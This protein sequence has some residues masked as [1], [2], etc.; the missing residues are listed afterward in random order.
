MNYPGQGIFAGGSLRCLLGLLAFGLAFSPAADVSAQ[1]RV[2]DQPS[3]VIAIARGSSALLQP[4]QD[5]QRVLVGDP[6]IADYA[7]V[8]PQE[9]VINAIGVG[10][11]SLFVWDRAD[12]VRMYTVAVTP[13]VGAL[14]RQLDMLFP[15]T[16]IELTASGEAV[17]VSGTIRDSRVARRALEIL[18]SSGVQVIDNLVAP[19]AKQILL[20]V[21]FAEVDR[22]ILGNISSDL[23]GLNPHEFDH[24]SKIVGSS[25]ET[26][27]EGIVRLLLLGDNNTELEWFLRALRT[28]GYFK[29]LAEPNLVAVEGQE[30][31]FLAGGEFPYPAVQGGQNS[32]VS[33]QWKEFGVVLNFTP[34]ITNDGNIRL[35]VAPEVSSLDFANGLTFSGFQIPSVIT[36]RAETQVELRPGQSFAIAGLLDNQQQRDV[37]QI[38]ILGQIPIIGTFFS[39]KGTRDLQTELLVVVTPHIVQPTDDVPDL[40]TGQPADWNRSDYFNEGNLSLPEGVKVVPPEEAESGSG[41]EG[42]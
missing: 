27:S 34:H 32:Q 36:R 31:S 16:D 2:I 37:D 38:P 30:A 29:S 8:S 6:S 26:L 25:L 13:D 11:T 10:S 39:S 9:L 5:V 21:R 22:S 40:P 12:R 23:R 28:E 20:H 35:L 7:L 42:S 41:G 3:E 24:V 19:A 17:V 18:G 14:Q 4:A 33:I 15:E 1:E